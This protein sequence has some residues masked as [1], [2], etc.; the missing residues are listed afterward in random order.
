MRLGYLLNSFIS[1]RRLHDSL[2]K[3]YEG[4]QLDHEKLSPLRETT[5]F[6][7]VFYAGE[8]LGKR[9]FVVIYFVAATLILSATQAAALFL[10]FRAYGGFNNLWLV[11]ILGCYVAALFLLHGTFW[12]AQKAHPGTTWAVVSIIVLV[13]GW[14][15]LFSFGTPR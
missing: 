9:S 8:W 10:P 6:F 3:L 4:G 11:S 12:K 14:L 5:S 13:V 1:V 7:E 2:L 15:V